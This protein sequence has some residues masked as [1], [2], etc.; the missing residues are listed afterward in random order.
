VGAVI[1]GRDTLQ[2]V[3]MGTGDVEGDHGP[4]TGGDGKVVFLSSIVGRQGGIS[5]ELKV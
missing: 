3:D 2:L 1:R 4:F 5:N